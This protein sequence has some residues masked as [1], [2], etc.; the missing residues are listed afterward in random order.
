MSYYDKDL[1][2]IIVLQ[3]SMQFHDFEDTSNLLIN[4][5]TLN[6]NPKFTE[7]ILNSFIF[8]RDIFCTNPA[9]KFGIIDITHEVSS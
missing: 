8:A 3:H 2:R 5:N 7:T 6:M 4:I 1:K 9:R